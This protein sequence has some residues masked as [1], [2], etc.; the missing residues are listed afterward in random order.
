M[1]NFDKI[2]VELFYGNSKR[3]EKYN[4]LGK[5]CARFEA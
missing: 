2:K 5:K 3:I 1:L 4:F